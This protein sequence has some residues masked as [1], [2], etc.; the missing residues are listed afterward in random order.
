VDQVFASSNQLVSWL[1]RIDHLIGTA[2]A[3]EPSMPLHLMGRNSSQ[4]VFADQIVVR[5]EVQAF[6]DGLKAISR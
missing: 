6:G 4:Q 1:R 2:S 3:H 5:D